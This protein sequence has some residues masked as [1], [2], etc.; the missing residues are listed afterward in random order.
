MKK[1]LVYWFIGLLGYWVIPPPR[2]R[3][4]G[5]FRADYDVAYAIAPTGTTIVTQSI[6]L[7]NNL[8]NL[9]PQKY[10]ILIDSEKIKN[11]I[12]YDKR[13]PITPQ[14]IQKEGKT[15]ILLTFNEKVVGLGKALTFTLRFENADIAQ[16]NGSIWEVNVPGVADDPDIATY[17][18]S[19]NVPSSFGQNAYMAPLPGSSTRWTKSQMI[20]G[21]ISAAYG[22]TQYF[23]IELSYY[24]ENPHVTPEIMEIALPPDTAYQTITLETL[25]PKPASVVRD[26][27]GNWLARY[28]LGPN[29]KLE[30][31]A[32]ATAAITL[33]P[34]ENFSETIL[35]EEY[36]KPDQ[37]WETNDP[38]I[39]SLANQYRTPRAIYDY[40]VS[41]LSYDY[42]RVSQNPIR[43]GAAQSLLSPDQSVCMEFTDLFVAIAR[44][45][46]VPAREVVGYAYTTNSKLRPLSLVADVLHAWPEYYDS[47]LRVWVPVDPTW[48]KTTGGVN[49]FDKLDFNHI[50]FAIH[51]I[52]SR[53]P[54][55]AGSYRKQGKTGKDV[56]VGFGA[57]INTN[58]TN[59]LSTHID[60]PKQV[61][62]GVS[63][64]G[65][66]TVENLSGVAAQDIAVSVQST[67]VDV[68]IYR[69]KKSIPP[70][71]SLIIP[72]AMAIPNVWR[73]S[74][75]RISVDIN[76]TTVNA[77]FSIRPVYWI[78]LPIGLGMVSALVLLIIFLTRPR[79]LWTIFKKR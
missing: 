22:D 73:V 26:T 13:G 36:L 29:Q 27:D 45:A 76:G 1:L 64:N 49:Y 70:Y 8:T 16:K 15:E 39:T 54:Y 66:V 50:A 17:N 28:E 14:I 68:A 62:A 56:I 23:T 60:F 52:S 46:G 19:L 9:Y 12:A 31:S 48:A 33:T 58:T 61:V 53:T 51:G 74:E 79:I 25:D 71:G 38:A 59:E 3:A 35:P 65:Q 78:I 43:K 21:G 4:V 18:V 55:P 77:V 30:I 11:V 37:Y 34:K 32:R 6:S 44:S 20:Q 42:N 24:L 63:A 10:S 47:Q 69:E 5:E 41:K 75:G 7:T 40:V 72:I 67:P 2:V 57:P